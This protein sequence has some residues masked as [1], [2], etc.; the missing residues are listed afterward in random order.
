MKCIKNPH[1]KSGGVLNYSFMIK[2]NRRKGHE[3][4]QREQ[5]Y[6]STLSLTSALDENFNKTH[7]HVRPSMTA[8]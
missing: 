3:G 7:E 2:S 5:T 1:T 6:D 4:P 8:S